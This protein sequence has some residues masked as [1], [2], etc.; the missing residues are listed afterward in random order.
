MEYDSAGGRD[1]GMPTSRRVGTLR[2]DVFSA[3][4]VHSIGDV[5][6]WRPVGSI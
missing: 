3:Y 4:A 6:R 2:V 5:V 1:V